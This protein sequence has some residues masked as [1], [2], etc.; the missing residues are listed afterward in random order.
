MDIPG[1]TSESDASDVEKDKARKE[2]LEK[3]MCSASP[4]ESTDSGKEAVVK[5]E[6][7]LTQQHQRRR[8]PRSKGPDAVIVLKEEKVA[9]PFRCW[10]L[11]LTRG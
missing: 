2:S 6:Q 4:S 11:L 1:D 3:L 5:G 7:K 8:K 9:V 10:I